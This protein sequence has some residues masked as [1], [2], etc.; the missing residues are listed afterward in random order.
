MK[1]FSKEYVLTFSNLLG[2][3]IERRLKESLLT[4]DNIWYI[5]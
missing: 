5:A 3:Q 1:V 4:I 2:N